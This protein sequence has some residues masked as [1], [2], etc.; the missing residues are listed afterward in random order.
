MVPKELRRKETAQAFWSRGSCPSM[1]M[2][3]AIDHNK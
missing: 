2:G 1:E 3:I